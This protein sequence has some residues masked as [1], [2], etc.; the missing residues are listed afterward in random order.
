MH[1]FYD[2]AHFEPD[3][4]IGYLIKRLVKLSTAHIEAAFAGCELTMTHW[5]ALA[6]LRHHRADTGAE[7]AR[8]IGH[9][10]GATTRLID[11]LEA[12]GL[13]ERTRCAQDRRVQRLAV[14]PA[15]QRQFDAMTPLLLGVW[16]EVLDDFDAVEVETFILML[17]RMIATFEARGPNVPGIVA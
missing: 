5:S 7:L 9:D 4:S 16:N 12:R 6:L 10:S 14:T 1:P 11:G 2:I 13:I 15:G 8:W 17:S 3:R